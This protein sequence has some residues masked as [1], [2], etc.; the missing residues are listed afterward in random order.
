M[1]DARTAVGFAD[2]A[3]RLSTQSKVAAVRHLELVRLGCK[4][5][6][7]LLETRKKKKITKPLDANTC[8]IGFWTS[9]K[10]RLFDGKYVCIERT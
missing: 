1:H 10:L 6:V 3:R 7:K 4:K 2:K 8:R 5:D 9:I